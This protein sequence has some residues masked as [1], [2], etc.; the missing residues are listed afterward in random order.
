M[1]LNT[2]GLFRSSAVAAYN[3]NQFGGTLGGPIKK[4]NTFIFG[5]YEGD[6][7]LQGISSGQVVL[8]TAAK[9]A[10]FLMA[11][12]FNGTLIDP[13]F[14]TQLANRTT[15]NPGDTTCAA[16]RSAEGGAPI[17]AGLRSRAFSRQSS[18]IK[19]IRHSALIPPR[20]LF[21]RMYVAPFRKRVDRPLAH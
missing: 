21:T 17:A 13:T 20:R 9:R 11:Q 6:R 15:G 10:G 14:A 7:L 3:Q 18:A 5:S 2:R 12:A 16:S 19:R 1:T 4:D 8:P